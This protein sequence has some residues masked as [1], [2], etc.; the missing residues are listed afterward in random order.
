MDV[1]H[2]GI[3]TLGVLSFIL[4]WCLALLLIR[5]LVVGH[6]A[7]FWMLLGD[8][9]LAA[10]AAYLIYMGRRA[11]LLAKGQPRPP[12]RFGWGRMLLG[13]GLIF[14]ASNTQFHLFPTQTI[15]KPLEYSNPTQ[16]AAGN[17]TTIAI[18]IGCVFLIISGIWRGFRQQA[19][20]PPQN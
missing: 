19:D 8:L 12:A 9:L 5:V 1:K 20:R 7:N 6:L 10:L 15:V 17:A 11:V 14:S 2:R 3:Q 16:A 18:C 4:G 13:A